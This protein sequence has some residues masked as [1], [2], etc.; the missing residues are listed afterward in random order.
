MSDVRKILSDRESVYG[1][2]DEFTQ[3]LT[4][5]KYVQIQ[6]KKNDW[7]YYQSEAMNMILLKIARLINGDP[8][9]VDTWQDIAGYAQLVVDI[10]EE[11]SL[12]EESK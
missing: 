8:N 10:L 11:K 6:R 12:K 4:E 1:S 3:I 5:L 9:H 2:Y 7:T